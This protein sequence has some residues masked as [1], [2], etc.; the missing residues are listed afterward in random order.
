MLD[1]LKVKV[2]I[3]YLAMKIYYFFFFNYEIEKKIIVGL[4]DFRLRVTQ[5]QNFFR[6]P[7][8][9]IYKILIKY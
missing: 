7:K 1:L 5:I 4:T 3:Y 9:N 8:N 2:A 6:K